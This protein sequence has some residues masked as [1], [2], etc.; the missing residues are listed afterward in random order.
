MS[1]I[2]IPITD[3]HIHIDIKNGKGLKAVFDF[4]NAGGTHMFLVTL[5]SRHLGYEIT[6]S[7]DYKKIFDET[8]SVTDSINEKTDV[9]AFPVLGIHPVEIIWLS[10]KYGTDKAKSIMLK[11]FDIAAEYVSENKAV[12]L[13]TGRPHFETEE[14]IRL[15]SDEIMSYVFSLAHDY[16]FPVQLHVE[17]MTETSLK[18]IF[19]TAKKEKLNPQKIINHHATP[20]IKEAEKYGIYPSITSGKNMVEKALLSGSRFLME[21]DYAD[22]PDRPGFVLGPKTVPK[23]TKKL[24][25]IYGEEPFWE[26]HKHIPEKIYGVDIETK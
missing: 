24:I 25:E 22:D 6:C 2:N 21:T 26:I 11:G 15:A 7:N 10:E 17:D 20:L 12:A 3:N 14:N 16:G 5:P 23:K 19:E 13:K 4:E 9:V 8:I 1:Q 18:N